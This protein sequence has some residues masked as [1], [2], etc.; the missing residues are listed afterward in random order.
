MGVKGE[1]QMRKL[2][3]NKLICKLI[4]STFII[5]FL[6]SMNLQAEE[7]INGDSASQNQPIL[8]DNDA[9]QEDDRDTSAPTVTVN[10]D[11]QGY[12]KNNITYFSSDVIISGQYQD[13]VNADS[14]LASVTV[15]VNGVAVTTDKDGNAITQ[16]YTTFAERTIQGGFAINT[17]DIIS[18]SGNYYVEVTATDRRGNTATTSKTI[19]IDK[20]A[21]TA[22]VSVNNVNNYYNHYYSKDVVMVNVTA[23]VDAGAGI[24]EVILYVNDSRYT[25]Q[26]FG[27]GDSVSATITLWDTESEITLDVV[28][29]VGNSVRLD[30]FGHKIYWDNQPPEVSI[31]TNAVGYTR[32]NVTYFNNDVLLT[33]AYAETEIAGSGIATARVKINDVYV[34]N[35]ISGNS[36]SKNYATAIEPVMQDSF[37][38]NTSESNP[39]DQIYHIEAIVTDNAGNTG[40]ENREIRIDHT[41]PEITSYVVSC[42]SSNGTSQTVNGSGTDQYVYFSKNSI[43]I[44][45]QATDN[46]GGSGVDYIIYYL[47]DSNGNKGARQTAEV[48]PDGKASISVGANFKGSICLGACDMVGNA[49][50]NTVITNGMI[51]ESEQTFAR[52]AH[53]AMQVPS[54]S[55]KDVASNPLYSSG[56]TIPVTITDAYSGINKVEWKI[57]SDQGTLKNGE[58]T[59]NQS[60]GL[61]SGG[62]SISGSDHNLVTGLKG[63]IVVDEN[64][65]GLTLWIKMTNNNG[66]S[67][68]R[69]VVLSVDHSLPVID[70]TLGGTAGDALY[71]EVHAGIC[72]VTIAIQERNFDPSKVIIEVVSATG[73]QPVVSDWTASAAPG[74]DSYLHTAV[75]TFQE[76]DDY[77]VT[78]RAVDLAGNQSADSKIDEFTIDLTKPVISINYDQNAVEGNYYFDDTR[79]ATISIVEHNF[80]PERIT[81]SGNAVDGNAFPA[82]TGWKSEGDVHTTQLIFAEDGEYFFSVAGMDQAG[83]IANVASSEDF[84]IDKTLPVINIEGVTDHSANHGIVA[85]M[86]S[87]TDSNYDKAELNISLSGYNSGEVI[88]EGSL[89]DIADGQEYK[90]SDFAYQPEQDDI[91]TLTVSTKDKAGNEVSQTILFS[92]NRFGSVYTIDEAVLDINGTYISSPIDVNIRET[93]TD[94][95]VPDSVS[96]VLTVNGVPR[97]LIKGVDYSITESGEEGTWKQYQYC[98]ARDLFSS[99]GSYWITLY[100]TDE[101]GNYNSNENA[102]ELA[103]IHFGV[104]GTAPNIIP[105][106]I[107]EGMIYE[108]ADHQAEVSIADNLVLGQVMIVLND[109]ETAYSVNDDIYTFSI[110]ES[111][112]VQSV[113]IMVTD[114]AGNIQ[115]YE[116]GNMYISSD[117]VFCWYHNKPLFW[118]TIIGTGVILFGTGVG[119]GVFLKHKKVR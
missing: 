104:D 93:N 29:M 25:S 10:T 24:K 74:S 84:F 14:G 26:Y 97:T 37:T 101:A 51:V 81:I 110:P 100:S 102:T 56:V 23:A 11:R 106:N 75:L 21:P 118:G 18:S 78:V 38:I 103:E 53:I 46:E 69:K 39:A 105:I 50:E 119:V 82:S 20:T 52:D 12:T 68:E 73:H 99:D 91:Y 88:V 108:E 36:V 62:W 8:S 90:M 111:R 89:S 28:D 94:R 117:P 114:L 49:K 95:L 64:C 31:S 32:D 9:E 44:T 112:E 79:T 98:L 113:E 3:R 87:I 4:A 41:A 42:E 70:L 83:N 77:T 107:E 27:S 76:D 1:L 109:E 61:S 47:V 115:R 22:T 58:I 5:L 35:D 57:T 65:N 19:C 67:Q 7:G 63:N 85:P 71:P 16:D 80:D 86:I 59:I 30:A 66:Y 33:I 55:M 116:A 92:V 2:R 54:T 48:L 15:K 6:F 40:T 45:V 34:A 43:T 17:A 13:N 96:V 72:T 60:G